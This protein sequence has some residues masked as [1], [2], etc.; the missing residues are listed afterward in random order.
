VRPTTTPSIP[1]RPTAVEAPRCVSTLP[2]RRRRAKHLGLREP[3]RARRWTRT[4]GSLL[5]AVAADVG[6]IGEQRRPPR[7]PASRTAAS[8][9][10]SSGG[11]GSETSTQPFTATHGRRARRRDDHARIQSAGTAPA[12]NAAAPLAARCAQ[13]T[14]HRAA[15][16]RSTDLPPQARSRSPPPGLD[17]PRCRTAVDDL[18]EKRGLLSGRRRRAPSRSHH[19]CRSL[20]AAANPPLGHRHPDSIGEGRSRHRRAPHASRTQAAAAQVPRQRG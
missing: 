7:P 18:G 5:G 4:V 15:G 6:V 1:R 14:A 10:S 9:A 17:R 2:R 16:L 11:D 20:R 8:A 19:V 13:T 3:R 12:R